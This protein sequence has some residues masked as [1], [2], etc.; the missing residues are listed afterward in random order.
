VTVG[1]VCT[2]HVVLLQKRDIACMHV[3][4]FSFVLYCTLLQLILEAFY[5]SLIFSTTVKFYLDGW[6]AHLLVVDFLLICSK[7]YPDM[8]RHMVTILRGY[9]YVNCMYLLFILIAYVL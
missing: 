7:F 5:S 1:G 8:F 4:S 2:C 9:T 3:S 6:T